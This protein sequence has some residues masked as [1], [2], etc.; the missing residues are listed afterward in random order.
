[1][2]YAFQT[3]DKPAFRQQSLEAGLVPQ[4]QSHG[5]VKTWPDRRELQ[6]S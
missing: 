4:F 2:G 3:E 6:Y 1:M 5:L